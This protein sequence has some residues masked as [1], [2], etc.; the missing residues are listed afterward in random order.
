MRRKQ[1]F[2]L[3]LENAESRGQNTFVYFAEEVT[4]ILSIKLGIRMPKDRMGGSM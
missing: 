1:R 3:D 2:L 4:H